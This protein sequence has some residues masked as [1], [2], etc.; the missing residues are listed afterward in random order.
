[1][2][3]TW[4][5]HLSAINKLLMATPRDA[6]IRFASFGINPKYSISAMQDHILRRL[7]EVNAFGIINY[8]APRCAC[9]A[10]ITTGIKT[11]NNA[12]KIITHYQLRHFKL[13]CES[14]LKL[15]D[16]GVNAITGGMNFTASNWFDCSQKIKSSARL[17]AEFDKFWESGPV[18]IPP[19]PDSSTTV[20]FPSGKYAGYTP[21]EVPLDYCAW[22]FV[23]CPQWPP[24]IL[25]ACR[26]VLTGCQLTCRAR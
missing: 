19:T 3:L 21:Q 22:V 7:A 8:M 12:N 10:C 25:E 1:M 2:N 16:N 4:D 23:N 24:A 20:T 17:R 5:E 14:H 11:Y 15:I 9:L 26:K 6:T 13:K 18:A